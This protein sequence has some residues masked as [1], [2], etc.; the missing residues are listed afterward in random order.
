METV[1]SYS[2]HLQWGSQREQALPTLSK[3]QIV[4]GFSLNQEQTTQDFQ[5]VKKSP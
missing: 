1:D 2:G 3:L 4:F 5:S